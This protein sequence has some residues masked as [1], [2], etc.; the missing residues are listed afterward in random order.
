MYTEKALKNTIY[1]VSSLIINALATFVVRTVFVM[2]LGEEILGVNATIIDT[3]NLLTMSEMGIQSA[4]IYKMYKPI[5]D[6]DIKRQCVLF[7]LYRNAYR[8]VALIILIIG[9]LLVPFIPQVVKSEIEIGLIYKAYFLQLFLVTATY[10]VSYYKIILLAYQNQYIL[11]YSLIIGFFANAMFNEVALSPNSCGIYFIVIGIMT[12]SKKIEIKEKMIN[13]NI[14]L[15]AER[16]VETNW[17]TIRV[18]K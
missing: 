5:I 18:F 9:L 11:L 4:I 12:V 13:E 10:F 3:V 6:G 2:Y 16:Q 8:I 7:N 15:H 14:E 1:N 17:G